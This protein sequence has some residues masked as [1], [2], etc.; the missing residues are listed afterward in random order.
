MVCNLTLAA[1]AL[2]CVLVA[3]CGGSGPTPKSTLDPFLSAW[4]RGDW[5]AMRRLVVHP[6]ANFVSANAA[7]FKALGVTHATFTAGPVVQ[8]ASGDQAAATVTQH[9]TLP[10][11]G[12]FEPQHAGEARQAQRQVAGLVVDA[13]DQPSS[14]PRRV[15]RR[16]PELAEASADPAP[17]ASR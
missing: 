10:Q 14:R 2:I 13:H 4:S 17:A 5:A 3:A 1:A 16:Q 12:A 9:Y 6:P 15:A 7:A 11:I 8:S